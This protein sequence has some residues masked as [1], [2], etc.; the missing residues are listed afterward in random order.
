MRLCGLFK[1]NIVNFKNGIVSICIACIMDSVKRKVVKPLD[2]N[3]IS[4]LNTG[5]CS[6][7]FKTRFTLVLFLIWYS[8]RNPSI[9][10]STLKKL[11]KIITGF[12]YTLFGICYN[13]P[14]RTFPVK[15]LSRYHIGKICLVPIRQNL[16]FFPCHAT[17][18]CWKISVQGGGM[19]HQ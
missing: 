4:K 17:A 13:V 1:K 3:R 11:K 16:L 7:V 14:F 6:D 9:Q 2:D 12:T 8:D 18:V 19:N 5:T 15:F 10:H